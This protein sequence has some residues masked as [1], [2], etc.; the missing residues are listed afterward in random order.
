MN[1]NFHDCMAI[2]YAYGPPDKF[3]TTTCNPN[4]PKIKE[5]LTCEIGQTPPDHGDVVVLSV[6][7]ETS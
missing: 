4:W 3:T 6:P 7:H 5:A 1:Q 2:C